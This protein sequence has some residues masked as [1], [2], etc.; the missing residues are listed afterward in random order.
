MTRERVRQLLCTGLSWLRESPMMILC[1]PL[2]DDENQADLY[3]LISA[4][5]KYLAQTTPEKMVERAARE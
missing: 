5:N 2:F 4:C 3:R 1:D